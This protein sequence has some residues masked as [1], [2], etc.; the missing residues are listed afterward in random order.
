MLNNDMLKKYSINID[1]LNYENKKDVTRNIV[2]SKGDL[3][4][5]FVQA[6]L[7]VGGKI[8]D[9][10]GCNVTVNIKN[11][12][13]K[14]IV[15]ACEILDGKKGSVLIPFT[16]T[17]LSN[18]GFNKFE[19]VVTSNNK[20]IVSPMLDYRVVDNISDKDSIEGTNEYGVLVV[21][22]KQVEDVLKNTKDTEDR[23]N[24]LESTLTANEE[25]RQSNEN[26]R[27]ANENTRKEQEINRQDIFNVKIATID[28]R[29]DLVDRKL[30]SVDEII[31]NKLVEVDKDVRDIIN[32]KF[33]NKVIEIEEE[34]DITINQIANESFANANNKINE[35]IDEMS[36]SISNVN[37]KIQE[38]DLAIDENVSKVNDKITEFT[39][40]KD[41]LV[42]TVNTT[43]N[44]K[45]SEIDSSKNNL[46]NTIN[47]TLDGKVSEFNET[48]EVLINIVD[49][50]IIEI[51]AKV[52]NKISEV[53][54]TKNSLVTTVNN[55]ITEVNEVK[56]NLVATVDDKIDEFEDRFSAL[57]SA[58]ATGEVISARKDTDGNTHQTLGKR[59]EVDF[60]KKADASN[61]YSK[62]EM[63]KIIEDFT[64]VD[65]SVVNNK[66]TWSSEKIENSLDTIKTNAE[67]SAL[68]NA[69]NILKLQEQL[70]SSITFL[71]EFINVIKGN[72]TLYNLN[73]LSKG[74]NDIKDSLDNEIKNKK[75]D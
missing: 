25:V 39:S 65:D 27:I 7:L 68:A 4:T 57:E 71:S 5:A 22:L 54:S 40:T 36:V 12:E 66:N 20:Q 9:L 34:I 51:D 37:S 48:K 55:K 70:S 32:V 17:A 67:S 23:V 47:N 3:D 24:I 61:V 75:N 1:F 18:L 19:V 64:L 14:S 63:D 33:D 13:G 30:V 41:N 69:N 2:Y 11:N 58:N 59:L 52:N 42:T 28:D 35:K 56:D 8:I 10:E 21:L 43:L 6:T 45:I 74:I 29:V 72:S 15:N 44:D 46:I 62:S 31:A 49:D 73:E 50:K 60:G 38:M 26:T 16:T 53:D